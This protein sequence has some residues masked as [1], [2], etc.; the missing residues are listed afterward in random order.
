MSAT[1]PK[2]KLRMAMIGGGEGGFIGEIHRYAAALCP[3]IELV[4]GAFSSNA[5]VSRR[6]GA[7]LGLAPQ[8][9]YD[10]YSQLIKQEALLDK[11]QRV[12]FISIV[13]PNFLHYEI[14]QLALTAGFHVFCDKPVTT[15]LAQAKSLQT[16]VANSGKHFALSHVYLG[17]PLVS[18]AKYMV[19]NGDF[20]R[21]RK[22]FVDYPQGWL[23]QNLE[24]AGNRQAT[25]RTNPSLAGGSGCIGDIGSHAHNL[26]EYIVGQNITEVCA[27]L[28]SFVEGRR[29][30]DD[31]SALF[32]M[33]G[34]VKG[35][36]TASQVCAGVENGLRISVFGETGGCEW[37][38]EQPNSLTVRR[39]GQPISTYRAGSDMSYLHEPVRN[40]FR[41][42]SGH[43]E[44]FIE[45]FANIYRSFSALLWQDIDGSAMPEVV[46]KCPG[47]N[48][49]VR[50]MQ[51][52]TAM[53]NSSA[54][55]GVWTSLAA[56][57]SIN[58]LAQEN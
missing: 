36:L 57:T 48:D 25:W 17:Y 9:V 10:D 14:A 22:V 12:D 1:G 8:R 58:T 37:C 11:N 32:R 56:A 52:I 55:G 23:A 6:S 38:Q 49:G 20:G 47:I 31:G 33:S 4:A 43:P 34:G 54:G 50:G 46:P 21:I 24:A 51:F 42:P 13:T 26:A 29:L 41:T 18:Q 40:S 28:S 5:E 30:D 53:V 3:D 27:E 2:R 19:A 44:G 35:V 39:S 16:L 7:N 15:T 45:A